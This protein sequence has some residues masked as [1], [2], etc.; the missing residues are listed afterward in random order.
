MSVASVN[1][2]WATMGK[3]QEERHSIPPHAFHFLSQ[4]ANCKKMLLSHFELSVSNA[5]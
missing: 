1:L 5:C 3:I 2:T 4:K